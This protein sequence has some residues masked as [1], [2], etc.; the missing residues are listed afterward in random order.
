[1]DPERD[2]YDRIV[3]PDTISTYR[4]AAVASLALSERFQDMGDE[5]L[6]R[7]ANAIQ[8][9]AQARDGDLGDT[10]RYGARVTYV[11]GDGE[12]HTA[13]VMEP[14]V[15]QMNATQAWDP[16][17][18][19]YVNPQEAYP[20]GTVQLVYTP[21][22]GLSDGFNFDRKDDL[23]V[24]TS[25]SPATEPGQTLCYYSGWDYALSDG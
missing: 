14:E 23:E 25:V 24:A 19:E 1:M 18:E 13:L 9:V 2:A 15:A 20:Y 8:S 7:L 21:G 3:L 22:F 10:S 11:D 6:A 4:D 5:S 12:A 17:R 16:H